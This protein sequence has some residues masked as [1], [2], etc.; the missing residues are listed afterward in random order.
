MSELRS[1]LIECFA[2]VFPALP[3]AEI[4][5]A[6]ST[7]VDSW[8]SMA[9]ATLIATIEEEFGVQVEADDLDRLVSFASVLDFLK[10]KGSQTG[11]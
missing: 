8:D 7:T 9:S 10:A 6:S 3:E 4:P 1:R 5:G 2:A 11:A